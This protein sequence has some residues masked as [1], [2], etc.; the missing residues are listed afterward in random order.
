MGT[1]R[2]VPGRKTRQSIRTSRRTVLRTAG[3]GALALAGGVT[4][5]MA[6]SAATQKA[7]ASTQFGTGVTVFP[8]HETWTASPGTEISFR[9]VTEEELGRLKVLGSRS[10]GKS[11]LLKPH[12]DGNGLSYVPDSRF[13]P[14]EIVTVQADVALALTG[15][16][17]LRF[18][19]VQPAE[20]TPASTDRT[21]DD[22]D[23]SP[24][25]F[26][27]RPDLRP[28]V[29]EITDPA[30]GTA[31]GY[32]FVGAKV[33][34]GQ[35]GAM[36][37]DN[38]GDPIWF[39]PPPSDL[40]SHLDVRVQDYRGEPVITFVEGHGPIGY[41][42]GHFVICNIAYDR[43]AEFQ[44]G[45][46]YTG[47]DHH[48]FT[49]TSRNTALIGCYHLVKWDLSP[50]GGSKY[51]TVLDGVV[52]ELEIETGRVLFEWHSLD[53]IAIDESYISI[54]TDPDTPYD[55]FHL[56]SIGETPDGNLIINARHTFACYKLNGVTG[57]VIWRLNGK[58]SDFS[59]APGSPFAWQHDA[60]IQPN[61][62]LT[63]FDNVSPNQD[64]GFTTD[65]RGL[66]LA[67]DE[68][69]MTASV[70]R[71]YIH[72]TGIL[73]VSQANTQILPNGNVFIGWGSAPV[74]SEFDPNGELLFNGRFPRGGTSYRAYRFPWVAEPI[75]PPDVAV[76]S[77][78]DGMVNVY[79]SW[80]GA[81]EVASWSVLAGSNANLLLPVGSAPRDGFETTISVQSGG[82]FFAVQALDASDTV[83]GTSATIQPE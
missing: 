70:A 71:E 78:A 17:A 14:G 53:H 48:E 67:L 75:D 33:A 25:T 49:L 4:W 55:Y 34:R 82:P 72:P 21:T 18:G 61:G 15:D 9:G 47:G 30:N 74:F 12:A 83:I 56:N 69:E 60:R 38:D 50:Y 45:N 7:R 43:I 13:E 58:Q 41:S 36:I 19:V 73:S 31:D 20:L 46:G 54:P 29:M 27:S 51:G 64:A 39:S 63:L 8:R 76:D 5:R 65:S 28:P 37:L 66:V 16:R 3:V 35:G 57:D 26:R 10:G 2:Q 80:N 81:T 52:Q 40:D 62:E 77:L 32:V 59:M 42:H 68:S 44:F 23:V 11:G 1:D 22:P 6:A 79:A 24:H